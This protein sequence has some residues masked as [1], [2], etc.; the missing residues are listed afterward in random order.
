MALL[1]AKSF[2]GPLLHTTSAADANTTVIFDPYPFED[3]FLGNLEP[4]STLGAIGLTAHYAASTR[5][6]GSQTFVMS[7]AFPFSKK[8]GPRASG[9]C[10]GGAG[11]IHDFNQEASYTYSAGAYFWELMIGRTII[12]EKD[13]PDSGARGYFEAA[14]RNQ[15]PL[16]DSRFN[17]FITQ[18]PKRGNNLD[19]NTALIIRAGS[20][21]DPEGAGFVEQKPWK[22]APAIDL[23]LHMPVFNQDPVIF[24]GQLRAP[25]QCY[26]SWLRCN[27]FV[28]L[29][30]FFSGQIANDLEDVRNKL[31]LGSQFLFLIRP[32]YLFNVQVHWAAYYGPTRSAIIAAP[33]VRTSFTIAF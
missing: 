33:F 30:R 10:L 15:R 4:A 8:A 12:R 32:K 24:S 27:P 19:N 11:G 22:V 25:F 13:Y 31:L 14:F 18:H 21:M 28:R 23:S 3:I 5:N 20:S 26:K 2:A 9:W 17:A 16:D 7:G 29:T 6:T 1:A